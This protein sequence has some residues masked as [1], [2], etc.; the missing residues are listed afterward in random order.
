[1]TRPSTPASKAP[2]LT[3]WTIAYFAWSLV[4]VALLVRVSLAEP[5]AVL[6]PRGF[7]VAWY[8][9]AFSDP[10]IRGAFFHSLELAGPTALIATALGVGL[11]VGLGSWKSRWSGRLRPL[12]LAPMAIPQIVLA[13]GA[14]YA[15][16]YPLRVIGFGRDAQLIAHITI[17]L[18]YVVLLVWSRFFSIS[19]GLEETAIDLGASRASAFIRVTL[20]LL[21][22][23]ILAGMALAFVLSFDNLVVSQI[24]CVRDCTTVPMLLYGRGRA[25]SVSPAVVALG[26][27]SA[28]AM[29][30][31]MTVFFSAWRLSRRWHIRVEG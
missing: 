29:L 5:S 14:F 15:F 8:R 2:F 9:M 25:V 11:G 27:V 4:P 7:S 6:D 12:A 16:L 1:M 31:A 17:A 3:T 21:L 30:V 18:P 13:A 24:L 28:M 19:R 10:D 26:T 22:P 23:A 20:P